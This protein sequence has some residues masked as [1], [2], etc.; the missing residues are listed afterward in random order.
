VKAKLVCHEES[1][2]LLDQELDV[3]RAFQLQKPVV[4]CSSTFCISS[5]LIYDDSH[6]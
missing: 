5:F 4:Y 6:W 3:N 2:V 1:N